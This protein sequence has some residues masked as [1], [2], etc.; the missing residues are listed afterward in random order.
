MGFLVAALAT[1]TIDGFVSIYFFLF[2][3]IITSIL[4]WGYITEFYSSQ[5]EVNLFY[6]KPFS[7]IFLS[8]LSNYL[9]VNKVGAFSLMIVFFSVAGIPPLSGFL[10]KIFVIFGLIASDFWLTSVVI[11]LISS[12]SVFYYIRVVK[13]LFF[14]VKDLKVNNQ[15]IQTT[16]SVDLFDLY[17][18]IMALGLYLLFF[19]F[20]FPEIPMLGSHYIVLSTFGF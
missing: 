9:K 14:V 2:M 15:N 4:T 8:S 5:Q 19:F 18:T 13:I 12:I 1:N 10:S 6:N 20:L 11:V 7:P 3:Y 17:C 16:F